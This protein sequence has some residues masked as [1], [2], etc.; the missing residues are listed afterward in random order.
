MSDNK[1]RIL[2]WD[3][4][5][6]IGLFGIIICHYLIRENT[7]L[8]FKHIITLY[9]VPIFFVAAGYFMKDIPVKSFI[10]EKIKSLL[11]PYLFL[12]I[13][14]FILF[15]IKD[16]AIEGISGIEVLGRFL[17]ILYGSGYNYIDSPIHIY[18]IYGI[19]FLLGLFFASI[20]TRLFMHNKFR[21]L[22]YLGISLLGFFTRNLIWLPLS[23]QSG[24]LATIFVYGGILIKKY[25]VLNKL[26]LKE[27]LLICVLF[28]IS[29][30]LSLKFDLNVSIV[31]GYM[32]YYIAGFIVSIISVMFL[33]VVSMSIEKVPY[34]NNFLAMLGQNTLVILLV[35]LINFHIINYKVLLRA[36][37]SEDFVIYLS[38]IFPIVLN[39]LL[40][41]LA[42]KS[43]FLSK[44]FNIKLRREKLSDY[45]K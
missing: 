28:I 38:I 36:G 41:I 1:K 35:H 31:V 5:R 2:Y 10:K 20:F 24:M 26:K 30:I 23:I 43:K 8:S 22:I 11:I 42:N 45:I 14:L 15:V 6:L 21:G 17:S 3:I 32:S 29:V 27:K 44:M 18:V 25:D 33:L 9:D 39:L 40:I 16:I 19:W 7:Y 4:A 12:A 13:I 37:F 34:L